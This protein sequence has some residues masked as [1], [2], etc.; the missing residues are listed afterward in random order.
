MNG[1]G[2]WMAWGAGW[3]H[4]DPI[5][6]GHKGDDKDGERSRGMKDAG[7]RVPGLGSM[8]GVRKG[9]GFQGPQLQ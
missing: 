3:T 1:A 6:V 7:C 5:K 2:P 4:R 9:E 8:W